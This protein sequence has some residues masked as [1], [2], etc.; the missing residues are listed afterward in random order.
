MFKRV[1]QDPALPN[2]ERKRIVRLIIADVTLVK[3]HEIRAAIRF[4][5]GATH[6]LH[7]PLPRPF[8]Q[9]RTT[10]PET[11]ATIDRLLDDYVDSEVAEQLNQKHITTLEG[12]AFT[13]SHVSALRRA[14]QLKSRYTRLREAGRQ[15]SDEVATHYEVTRQ[16]VWR[17]YHHGLIQGERY[18][19]RILLPNLDQFSGMLTH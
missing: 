11:I 13:G 3:D 18:I 16:T 2:R 15:T 7:V 17:W 12:H 6:T 9:A 10:L 4:R 1:W 8:A 19:T 5:G 14:H